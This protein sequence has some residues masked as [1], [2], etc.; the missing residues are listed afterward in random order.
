M[1]ICYSK[2]NI[3]ESIT[4]IDLEKTL[5]NKQEEIVV[6]ETIER[7]NSNYYVRKRSHSIAGL[8]ELDNYYYVKNPRD[9]SYRLENKNDL[10]KLMDKS[11]ILHPK[12]E[13]KEQILKTNEVD[14]ILNRHILKSRIILKNK[15]MYNIIANLNE[16][17]SADNLILEYNLEKENINVIRAYKTMECINFCLEYFIDIIWIDLDLPKGIINAFEIASVLE[18]HNSEITIIGFTKDYGILNKI[19]YKY[20]H[21]IFHLI[22]FKPLKGE[23]IN[24]FLKYY[25]HHYKRE[26]IEKII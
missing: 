13:N 9:G 2:K 23:N 14:F 8:K 10:N 7:R 19:M 21:N 22:F 5:N 18:H 25:Y 16:K 6:E 12:E 4:I 20:G 15:A 1:G 11:K 24:C 26:I 3:L 17:Y